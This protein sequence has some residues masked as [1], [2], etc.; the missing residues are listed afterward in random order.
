MMSASALQALSYAVF[1]GAPL[2]CFAFAYLTRRSKRRILSKV[3]VAAGLSVIAVGIDAF[4]IEP[5]W[6]QVTHYSVASSKIKAPIRIG[7]VADLQTDHVGGYERDAINRLLAEKPD[8]ILFPGDYIQTSPEHLAEETSKLRAVFRETQ[9]K[10]PLGAFAVR[11]DI[12]LP[13]DAWQQLIFGGTTVT[14][15]E[16]T[17]TLDRGDFSLTGLSY[18]DSRATDTKVESTKN[19]HIVFG[20]R[21]D[22]ALGDIDADLL[23]AGHTHGGQVQLPIIGPLLTATAV[24]RS[25]AK[26]DKIDLG[27]GRTLVISRGVGMERAKAPRL[28]FLCR[29]EIVIV[30]VEPSG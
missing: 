25:W 10:A 2:S 15:F 13:V 5:H 3:L 16:Q 26:G 4:A 8:M 9:L 11:G 12:E 1:C 23:I 18:K 7:V 22:F 14:G 27:N 6:L 21:P 28:R 24:P 19:F 17:A 30:D 29:P 20:H